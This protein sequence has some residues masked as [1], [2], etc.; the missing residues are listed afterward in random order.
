M[1]PMQHKKYTLYQRWARRLIACYPACWR[2]RYAEEMLLILEDSQPTLKTMLNL[3]LHLFDAY[4][5]QNLIKERTPYMLQKM[6]SN[7]LTIYGATLIFFVAWFIVQVHFVVIPGQPKVLFQS[8]S[9]TPS[10]LVNIIHS[11]SYLLP[12]LTLLGGLPILLAAIF[13]ALKER[14]VSLSSQG[15]QP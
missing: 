15:S 8:F 3:F 13:Q 14:K 1:Q 5:H 6:R 9:Y 7:E 4:L 2:Q 12:L 10:L 11:I